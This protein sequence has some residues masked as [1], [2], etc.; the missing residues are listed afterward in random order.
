MLECLMD[1]NV[2]IVIEWEGLMGNIWLKLMTYR[3]DVV[4]VSQIFSFRALS[5]SVNKHFII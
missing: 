3:L 4:T 2:Y 5:Y 1:K